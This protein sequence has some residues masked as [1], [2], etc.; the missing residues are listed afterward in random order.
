[1][2]NSIVLFILITSPLI[3]LGSR[4]LNNIR[5]KISVKSGIL[6][7]FVILLII[8]N[9][10]VCFAPKE[11]VPFIFKVFATISTLIYTI[12]GALAT[13]LSK[14]VGAGAPNSGKVIK[15]IEDNINKEILKTNDR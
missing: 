3:W 1:M 6:L 4:L 8:S 15:N 12:V 9:G 14:A 10:F 11:Y 13:G 7:S 5:R 2:L